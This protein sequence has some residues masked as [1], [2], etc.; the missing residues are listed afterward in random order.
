MYTYPMPDLFD[1]LLKQD[2][3][4]LRILAEFWGLELDSKRADAAREKLT[5]SL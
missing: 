4:H 2:I 5:V 3:G 1:S